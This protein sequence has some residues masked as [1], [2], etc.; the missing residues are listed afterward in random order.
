[1][2]IWALFTSG[3]NSVG[4][5]DWE[6]RLRTVK[7]R[8]IPPPPGAASWGGG[9]L[10]LSFGFV[11]RPAWWESIGYDGDHDEDGEQ[12]DQHRRHDQLDILNNNVLYHT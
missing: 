8:S 2:R 4:T 6:Y 12:Q 10:L 11:A 3:H 9:V 7:C 5:G 1:M